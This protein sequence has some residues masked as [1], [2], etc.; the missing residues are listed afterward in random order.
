ML[1]RH[2]PTAAVPGAACAEAAANP[3]PLPPA[4]KDV[5]LFLPRTKDNKGIRGATHPVEARPQA[6]SARSSSRV[7]DGSPAAASRPRR[8]QPP[9]RARHQHRRYQSGATGVVGPAS[10]GASASSSPIRARPPSLSR[11]LPAIPEPSGKPGY[12]SQSSGEPMGHG[13]PPDSWGC[14]CFSGHLVPCVVSL[15]SPRSALLPPPPPPA[16][17]TT[18]HGLFAAAVAAAAARAPGRSSSLPSPNLPP[19][20]PGPPV[21]TRADTRLRRPLAGVASCHRFPEQHHALR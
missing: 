15:P 4:L 13:R 21:R 19:A 20:A 8:E 6:P 16:P 9:G 5:V 1:R 11:G 10:P 3:P 14:C 2:R 17:H 18:Q 12:C 7:Q